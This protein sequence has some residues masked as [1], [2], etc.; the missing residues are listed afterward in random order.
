MQIM[1]TS[2]CFLALLF[3][4]GHLTYTVRPLNGVVKD[5]AA[6]S[7]GRGEYSESIT[8]K[9]HTHS[10]PSGNFPPSITYSMGDT[11]VFSANRISRTL[12]L[13]S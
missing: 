8:Q 2:L 6:Y 3:W 13:T 7:P 9:E 5:A 1:K 4:L 12:T 10:T 11:L